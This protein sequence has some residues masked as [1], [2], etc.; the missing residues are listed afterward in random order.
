MIFLLLCIKKTLADDV[1]EQ[2]AEKDIWD[3]QRTDKTA[4]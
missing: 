4:E 2:S 1:G 3:L